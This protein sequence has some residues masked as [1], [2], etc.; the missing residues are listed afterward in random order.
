VA[1]DQE[2]ISTEP[3]GD[4][5]KKRQLRDS[6]LWP[7]QRARATAMSL[8]LEACRMRAGAKGPLTAY[9]E[10][11]AMLPEDMVR[12]VE[13][14]INGTHECLGDI[15]TVEL[16]DKT[17]QLQFNRGSAQGHV[18]IIID[19][20]GVADWVES[21]Q[22]EDDQIRE[23]NGRLVDHAANQAMRIRELED[24]LSHATDFDDHVEEAVKV[25]NGGGFDENMLYVAPM[26]TSPED[27]VAW[28]P[29]GSTES[30]F[31]IQGYS[32]SIGLPSDVSVEVAES[33]DDHSPMERVFSGTA[34]QFQAWL[35][36]GRPRPEEAPND[37]QPTVPMQKV[38]LEPAETDIPLKVVGVADDGEPSWDARDE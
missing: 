29:L 17:G 27:R 6:S 26:G 21:L 9:A 1:S 5:G 4:L 10:E 36:A 12:L 16:G 13:Y 34:E 8:V 28:V 32:G 33:P 7:A 30:G 25:G 14:I 19:P 37:E 20:E 15:T 35:D 11:F 18:G 23:H 3:G 2:T 22:R 31:S 24:Q 38:V